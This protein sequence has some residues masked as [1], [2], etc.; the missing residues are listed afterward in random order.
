M[1]QKQHRLI[2]PIGRNATVVTTPF[3][4]L[5]LRENNS[6]YSRFGF[7][8]SKKI[9]KSAVIRNR[10]RRVVRSAVEESLGNIRQ[11]YDLL[12][13][14]TKTFEDEDNTAAKMAVIDSMKKRNIWHN[15]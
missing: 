15:D 2:T 3:F 11:G 13:I 12:F 5:K 10:L 1:L 6:Q 7:V 14:I 8:V 4:T 9:A